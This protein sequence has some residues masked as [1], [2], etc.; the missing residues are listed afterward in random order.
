MLEIGQHVLLS[1]QEN[2][3]FIH[4]IFRQVNKSITKKRFF[5]KLILFRVILCPVKMV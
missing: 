4:E 2:I 5:I 3:N 1:T